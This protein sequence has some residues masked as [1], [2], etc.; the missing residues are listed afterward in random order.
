MQP[1]QPF[2]FWPAKNVDTIKTFAFAS[3]ECK[4]NC[5]LEVFFVLPTFLSFKILICYSLNKT[6]YCLWKQNFKPKFSFLNKFR[7][8][9]F[10]FHCCCF[11]LLGT[12]T[13]VNET[14][15]VIISIIKIIFKFEATF[16]LFMLHLK[17]WIVVHLNERINIGPRKIKNICRNCFWI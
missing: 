5:E 7:Y 3:V 15:L 2:I 16:D 13:D 10:C 4:S 8:Y 6:F 9:F 1:I 11:V 17:G 12:A 14:C